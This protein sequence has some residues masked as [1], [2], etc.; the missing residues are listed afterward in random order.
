MTA[1][2]GRVLLPAMLG[3]ALP[4]AVAWLVVSV[5]RL[6]SA[7]TA[8]HVRVVNP[9]PGTPPL[10]AA[11]VARLAAEQNRWGVLAM[12]AVAA[13]AACLVL[14]LV[15]WLLGLQRQAVERARQS[16][17]PRSRV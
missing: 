13:V 15:V 7:A 14:T 2:P 16:D 1:H 12:F 3:L 5:V 6:T 17:D 11:D 4:A 9:A 8:W 10:P